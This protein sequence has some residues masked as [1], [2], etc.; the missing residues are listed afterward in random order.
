MNER[1]TTIEIQL[2]H[3]ENTIQQLNDVITRQQ[4]DIDKM[5]RDIMLITKHL[6]SLTTS[7]IRASEDEE[8][9]PHY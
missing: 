9:P 6:Q 3:H 8:P 4:L 2:M 1:I 5:Q 7:D